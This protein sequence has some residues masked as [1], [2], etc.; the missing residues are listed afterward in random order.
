MYARH[1]ILLAARLASSRAVSVRVF[2]KDFESD[3][4]KFNHVS[5]LSAPQNIVRSCIH[6]NV[7]QRVTNTIRL[8]L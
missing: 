3:A 4:W 1:K 5:S 7:E 6:L 2:G 8:Y